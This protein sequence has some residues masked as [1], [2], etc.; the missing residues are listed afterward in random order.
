MCSDMNAYIIALKS[1]IYINACV[2]VR[3][4]ER[5]DGVIRDDGVVVADWRKH[6]PHDRLEL[7]K[8]VSEV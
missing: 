6:G 1:I 7:I 5:A 8:R 4:R 2:C 3:R